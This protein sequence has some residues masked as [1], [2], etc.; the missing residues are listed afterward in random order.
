MGGFCSDVFLR[1]YLPLLSSFGV[2]NCT[3]SEITLA[4]F[5]TLGATCFNYSVF[6]V[7]AASVDLN[8]YSFSVGSLSGSLSAGTGTG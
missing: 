7:A 2:L 5:S 6:D 8:T 4:S 1:S 3:P